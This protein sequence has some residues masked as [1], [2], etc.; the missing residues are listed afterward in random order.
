MTKDLLNYFES[1]DQDHAVDLDSPCFERLKTTI[2]GASDIMQYKYKNNITFYVKSGLARKDLFALASS[3]MYND[4]GITNPPLHLGEIKVKKATFPYTLSEDVLGLQ[5]KT[6]LIVLPAE[7]IPEFKEISRKNRKDN[8]RKKWEPLTNEKVREVFLN[9]MTEECFEEFMTIHLLD[10]L[11]TDCDR[12]YGN[13]FLYKHKD[14]DKFEGVIPIDL[15]QGIILNSGIRDIPFSRFLRIPYKSYTPFQSY[16]N[17]GVYFRIKN[18]RKLLQ[19]GNITQKQ[20]QL[21]RQQLN[22]DFPQLILDTDEKYGLGEYASNLQSVYDN[23]SRLWEYNRQ[24]LR[25]DLEL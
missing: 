9:F 13:F 11:R 20:A 25:D 6:D 23:S 19:A 22:Y 2:L 12:H 24:E 17:I 10:E 1:L 3:Q 4:L 15:E 7:R 16:D 5:N 14:S 18:I 8:S 21:M